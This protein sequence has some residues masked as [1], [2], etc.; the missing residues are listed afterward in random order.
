MNIPT[1]AVQL[2]DGDLAPVFPCG[3]QCG[4]EA[5]VG[6]LIR[7]APLPV[8]TS[9][10]SPSNAMPSAGRN[11]AARS[12]RFDAE[13]RAAVLC[14]TYPNVVECPFAM[15]AARYSLYNARFRIAGIPFCMTR[16]A[17]C[18]IR[19]LALPRGCRLGEEID[20]SGDILGLAEK[21]ISEIPELFDLASIL[22]P[23]VEKIENIK[24]GADVIYKYFPSARS[25]FFSRP[26]LRFS[27]KEALNDPS[28]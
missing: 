21:Y 8:S 22:E 13:T 12:L 14:G 7:P 27:Q 3:C 4:L 23:D 10:N 6:G 18:C 19:A 20:S 26:Q 1:E 5:V 28:R 9:T 11:V 25:G 15:L 24:Y 17:R 16:L 2:G